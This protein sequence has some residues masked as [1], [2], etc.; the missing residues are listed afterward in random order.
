M[1]PLTS[2]LQ[3]LFSHPVHQ[4]WDLLADGRQADQKPSAELEKRRILTLKLLG[5]GFLVVVCLFW[6]DVAS[7]Y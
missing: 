1:L 2:I 3:T 6:S 4:T 7:K 5:E